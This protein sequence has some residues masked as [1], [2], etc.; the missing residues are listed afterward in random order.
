VGWVLEYRW[1]KC[2]QG[3]RRMAAR[4]K[5]AGIRSLV[6]GIDKGKGSIE[7][8]SVSRARFERGLGDLSLDWVE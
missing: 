8:L 3:F 4:N 7:S 6:Y 2:E 5:P 1:G